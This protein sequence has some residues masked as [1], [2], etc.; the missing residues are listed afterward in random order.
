MADLRADEDRAI[1]QLQQAGEDPYVRRWQQQLDGTI[2]YKPLATAFRT[3]QGDGPTYYDK[4]RRR[5][6]PLVE[7]K[8][9]KKFTPSLRYF[10]QGV[11]NLWCGVVTLD[12]PCAVA[13]VANQRLK[14]L[15]VI[16]RFFEPRQSSAELLFTTIHEAFKCLHSGR[17]VVN[18]HAHFLFVWKTDESAQRLDFAIAFAKRFPKA[19]GIERVKHR[20]KYIS[21]IMRTPD[22]RPL[23]DADEYVTYARTVQGCRRMCCYNTFRAKRAQWKKQGKTI[24][25]RYAFNPARQC[26]NLRLYLI[27]K[28]PPKL[29]RAAPRCFP[30][31]VPLNAVVGTTMINSQTGLLVATVVKNPTP[32]TLTNSVSPLSQKGLL[33]PDP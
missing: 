11:P 31:V 4:K 5:T 22:L 28:P 20:G 29:R 24:E 10:C 30:A 12:Q 17:A 18:V 23:L 33:H 26:D 13:E 7:A 27:D 2:Q 14:T 9:L 25:T 21:Y 32:E 19:S 15:T 1:E 6:L 3:P 16:R 8:A